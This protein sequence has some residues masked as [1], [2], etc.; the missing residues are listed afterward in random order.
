MN[1]QEELERNN[2]SG[3]YFYF[4]YDIILL[5]ILNL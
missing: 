5:F 3:I 4:Y 1:L 2:L